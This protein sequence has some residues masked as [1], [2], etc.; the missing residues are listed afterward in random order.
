MLMCC[1]RRSFNWR[2]LFNFF[3]STSDYRSEFFS[4][5]ITSIDSRTR[6]CSAS[7]A[8]GSIVPRT[9]TMFADRLTV[10]YPGMEHF[11]VR[12]LFIWQK[13]NTI[14]S[15]PIKKQIKTTRTSRDVSVL[16]PYKYTYRQGQC[17][18]KTSKHT[19]TLTSVNWYF[20]C[21]LQIWS[22]A[23]IGVVIYL[24]TYSPN[25]SACPC[26]SAGPL[27]YIN[28]WRLKCVD[29][30]ILLAGRRTDSTSG[31]WNVQKVL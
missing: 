13:P 19:K 12:Q 9:A 21:C 30:L 8:G 27:S 3:T 14:V 25:T 10:F 28:V 16:I 11:A 1:L 29:T 15:T 5:I 4:E 17:L 23:W 31:I 6:T 7:A 18:P 20:L 24:R 22:T 26:F 2:A